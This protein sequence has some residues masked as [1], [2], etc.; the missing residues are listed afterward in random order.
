LWAVE[1]PDLPEVCTRISDPREARVVMTEVIASKVGADPSTITVDVTFV[2]RRRARR[3][4]S[5]SLD[6][7]LRRVAD[8]W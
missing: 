3:R 4:G 8:P 2:E 7:W 5:A 1:V 6:D